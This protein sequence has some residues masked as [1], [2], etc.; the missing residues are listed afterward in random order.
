MFATAHDFRQAPEL[1]SMAGC[2]LTPVV[3]RIS[4]AETSTCIGLLTRMRTEVFDAIECAVPFERLVPTIDLPHDQRRNPLFQTALVLEPAMLEP[5]P[6]WSI[7]QMETAVGALVGQ[8]KLDISV[9][10]AERSDG[11]ICPI[12][13]QRRPFR[14]MYRTTHAESLRSAAAKRRNGARSAARGTVRPDERDRRR[15]F[16]EFNPQPLPAATSAQDRCIHE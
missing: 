6:T 8:S 9:G 16:D 11:R 2:R 15:Q 10:L 3:L 13:L 14:N 5:D 1:E 12:D 4:V 7:D